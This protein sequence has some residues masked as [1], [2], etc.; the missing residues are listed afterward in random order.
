MSTTGTAPPRR[1]CPASPNCAS[2][3]EPERSGLGPIPFR[4]TPERAREL[5]VEVLAALPRTTLVDTRERYLHAVCTSRLLRFQDDLE[6]WID[7]GERQIHYRSAA[8]VGY[9]DLG[10]NRRRV[11]DLAARYRAREAVE[12]ADR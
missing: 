11:L 4:V 3:F 6:L 9:S 1:P 5:L 7:D 10:V 8:R 12:A 2:S